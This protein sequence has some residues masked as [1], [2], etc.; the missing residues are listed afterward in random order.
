MLKETKFKVEN[1]T[2]LVLKDD[3]KLKEHMDKM[4]L[5]SYG[6]Q[7]QSEINP[8]VLKEGIEDGKNITLRKPIESQQNGG[9]V[10]RLK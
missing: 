10:K 6:G 7:S 9:E 8:N 4:E 5:G 1:E 3:P 2:G